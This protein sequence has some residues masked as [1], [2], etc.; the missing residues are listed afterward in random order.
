MKRLIILRHAKSDWDAQYDSD[1][2]RPLTKRGVRASSAIGIAIS[3]SREIPDVAITSSALRATTTIDLA[4]AAG[5]WSTTIEVSDALY[6]T[7]AQGALEVAATAGDGVER[8]MLVGHQPTWGSLVHALTGGSVEMKT[9]TAVGIALALSSWRDVGRAP[10]SI[11]YVL[12]PR[13]FTDGTW[14]LA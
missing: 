14:D 6:G 9:A 2:E 3:R 11:A 1:H 13:L 12:Q 5:N 8:L 7:S 4:A 10:G